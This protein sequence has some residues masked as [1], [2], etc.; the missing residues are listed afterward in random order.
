MTAMPN[1]SYRK[2]EKFIIRNVLLPFYKT[3]FEKL[4]KLTLDYVIKRKN[5]YLFK[6]K[7]IENAGEFVKNVLDAFLSSREETIFG[8]FLENLAIFICGEV[9]NGRKAEKGKYPSVDLIFDRNNKCYIVGIKSGPNW[10]NSDQINRMK[11]NFKRAKEQL[12]GEGVNK[13]IISVNG[14]M[15]GKD[16]KPF[17]QDGRDPEKSY[18]KLCGQEFWEFISGDK[19]LYK[20][21]IQPIDKEAKKRDK[22]FKALY[23][24]KINLMT[25]QFL[26]LFCKKGVIDWDG[27]IDFVSKKPR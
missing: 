19:E 16:R 4:K 2:I 24:K 8:D 26:E 1:L 27:I 20:T 11:N 21:I 13:E 14:C 9:F 25:E 23:S 17:K 10:G 18:Y 6:A 22:A 15:Y 5:P 3:R 12:R 7:N